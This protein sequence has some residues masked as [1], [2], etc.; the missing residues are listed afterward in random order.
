MNFRRC[1]QRSE[2]QLWCGN[3]G[4]VKVRC[5]QDCWHNS[6]PA[7]AENRIYRETRCR[8]GFQSFRVSIKRKTDLA[9]K[10]R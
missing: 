5:R 9:M 1:D 10:S 7:L 6:A 4:T 8:N 3:T 2:L